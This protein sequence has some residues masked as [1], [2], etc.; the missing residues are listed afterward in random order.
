MLEKEDMSGVAE[1]GA[2]AEAPQ[3]PGLDWG[4]LNNAVGTQ[5]RLLRNELTVR[6]VA[7]YAPFNLRGG[8][9]STLVLIAANPGCSQS[10]MAREM[11]IDDSAMVAIIDELESRGLA[12]RSRS[13]AD[14]RR[15]S[16]S[17]T[18]AGEQLMQDMLKCAN[19]VERPIRDEL[20][21]EEVATLMKLLRR[22]Y[23]ALIKTKPDGSGQPV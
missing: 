12:A 10:E 19:R 3:I 14:R 7:A 22:A 17:L 9:L 8:A 23:G 4:H 21:D 18:P 15:N 2:E 13:T 5:V 11:A 16:L 20:S 6:I 1:G